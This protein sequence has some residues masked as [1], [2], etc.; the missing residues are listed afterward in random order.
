MNRIQS[1]LVAILA[2]L[3]PSALTPR[4]SALDDASRQ[5]A[6]RL[7]DR[8]IAFLRAQQDPATGGW[9]VNP[10]GPNYPAIT[11]LV[12]TGMLMDPRIDCAD[13]SVAKGVGF[14]LSFQQPD[15]GIYDRVLPSYNTALCVSAL[16]RC[17]SD[18]AQ[19]AVRGA[20]PFLRSLQWS[21]DS[22]DLP[23]ETQKV[24]PD[25]PF[26][27][28]VGYGRHGRPDNSNLNVFVQALHDAGVP[29]SDPALQRALVFLRRTQM[30]DRVN[31][32][33]YAQ[34]SRQG[35]FVYATS[36][37][38]ETLGS[39]Q[40]MAGTMDESLPDGTTA[41]RLRCYGSMTYAGFKAMIYADLKRD[42][43]RV[44]AA[45][46]W[47]SRNYTVKENPGVGTD[48]LYYYYL[49]MARALAAWGEEQIPAPPDADAAPDAPTDAPSRDW[50]ADLIAQLATLQT[51]DG[52][53]RPVDDRWMEDN[54]V[55]ITAYALI[56]LQ[57]MT[58]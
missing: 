9:A 38:K 1:T 52:S 25:H 32:M 4:A 16:A 7:I 15:G 18:P 17:E 51:E 44:R 58:R 19:A 31:E 39:G 42:D 46:D 2:L 21:E 5:T 34:G 14:M 55:L 24:G 11:G 35:G 28:G 10:Q 20:V 6:Q 43:P 8:S 3:A 29:A 27:G 48:G 50:R 54:P 57:E 36:E 41:S 22:L 23:E 26:Y 13:E 40:S 33:P 56:A 45:Y 47:L 49:T 12:V 37:N 30:D 53:F